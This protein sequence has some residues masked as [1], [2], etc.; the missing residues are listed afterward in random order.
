MNV[1]GRGRR[2][3]EECEKMMGGMDE[4]CERERM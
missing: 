3:D 2:M 4:A 1:R